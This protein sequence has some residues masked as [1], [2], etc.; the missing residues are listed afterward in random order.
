MPVWLRT[1]Y[2]RSIIDFREKEQKHHEKAMSKSKSTSRS[3]PPK[4]RR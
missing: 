1:F 4:F 3:K 2:I